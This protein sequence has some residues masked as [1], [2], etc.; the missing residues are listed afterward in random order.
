MKSAFLF[1]ALLLFGVV[2]RTDLTAQERRTGSPPTERYKTSGAYNC[3]FWNTADQGHRIGYLLGIA[4]GLLLASTQIEGTAIT[5]RL[6]VPA[7]YYPK[8][9]V[10][11]GEL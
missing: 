10:S 7:Y 11:N 1:A 4:D 5:E 8:S 2:P 9:W 3:R 6:K